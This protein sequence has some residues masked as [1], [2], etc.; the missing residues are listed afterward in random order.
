MSVFHLNINMDRVYEI[1]T[2]ALVL[3]AI[4]VFRWGLM[5]FNL[6]KENSM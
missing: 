4:L 6:K 1:A 3:L 2:F 5:S